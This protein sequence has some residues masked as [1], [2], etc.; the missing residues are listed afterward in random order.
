MLPTNPSTPPHLQVLVDHALGNGDAVVDCRASS[1]QRD[2]EGVPASGSLTFDGSQTT[3]DAA[4]DLSCRFGVFSSDG[5]CTLNQ[6]GEYALLS[7]DPT[8]ATVKQFCHLLLI[9]DLFP[10]GDTVIA[11]RVLDTTG[12]AGPQTQIVVRVVP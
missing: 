8:D 4:T 7:P 6:F 3:I 1:S 5:A 11:A 2:W 10:V 12:N 9:S